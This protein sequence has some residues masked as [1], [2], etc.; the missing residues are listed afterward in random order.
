M[1]AQSSVNPPFIILTVL[2]WP[3]DS[4]V[5]GLHFLVCKMGIKNTYLIMLLLL[6]G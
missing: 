4:N 2:L 5:P 3:N 6:C 1:S